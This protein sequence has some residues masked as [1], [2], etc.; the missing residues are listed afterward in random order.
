MSRS[1]PPSVASWP[2]RMLNIR[3]VVAVTGLSKA[4]IYEWMP[5]GMFPASRRLGPNRVGWL[6]RD[7]EDFCNNCPVNE[8]AKA[9]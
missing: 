6:A 3:E 8:K 1:L 2:N 9:A 4:T 7:I 5:K